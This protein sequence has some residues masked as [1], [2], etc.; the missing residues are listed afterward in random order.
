VLLATRFPVNPASLEPNSES[1]GFAVGRYF[2]IPLY[3]D[4]SFWL[5]LL[6]ILLQSTGRDAS[7]LDGLILVIL[8]FGSIILHEYG[9]ALAARQCGFSTEMITLGMLG[10]VAHINSHRQTNLQDL[11]ITAAGPLVNLVIWLLCGFALPMLQ[12]ANPDGSKDA[13]LFWTATLGRMNLYLML[14]N[15]LPGWPLDGGRLLNCLLRFFL[16]PGKAMLI[17][18]YVAQATAIGL[19]VSAF[20]ALA[21]GNG[22]I[23]FR[24]LIAWMIWQTAGL[25]RQRLQRSMAGPEDS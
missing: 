5:I 14:F 4:R 23:V 20:I 16:S 2:G 11:W 6:V 21:N 10:G 9:H 19:A 3:I 22:F 8:L 24:L 15:L 7:L 1:P 18:T 13:A 17:T 12:A 25:Y